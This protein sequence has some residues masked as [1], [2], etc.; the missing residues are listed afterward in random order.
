MIYGTIQYIACFEKDCTSECGWINKKPRT[1][2]GFFYYRVGNY[3]SA[4]FHCR[5]LERAIRLEQQF[6]LAPP[7]IHPHRSGLAPDAALL[8]RVP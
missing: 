7:P 8:L 3:I 2:P 4:G 5:S 6:L 1:T